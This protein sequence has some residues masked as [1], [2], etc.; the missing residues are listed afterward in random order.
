MLKTKLI[1]CNSRISKLTINRKKK[2]T[3]ILTDGHEQT[4]RKILYNIL[5]IP[6]YVHRIDFKKIQGKLL[7]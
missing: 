3:N 1:Y 6:T 7:S 2:N 4:Q 5:H